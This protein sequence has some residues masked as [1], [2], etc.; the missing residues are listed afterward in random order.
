MT[1]LSGQQNDAVLAGEPLYRLYNRISPCKLGFHCKG[2]LTTE[3]RLELELNKAR[4]GSLRE[5]PTS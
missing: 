3:D 2:R 4:T 1:S 5:G